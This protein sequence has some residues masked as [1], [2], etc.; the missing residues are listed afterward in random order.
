MKEGI[1]IK[2]ISKSQAILLREKGLDKYVLNGHGQYHKYYVCENQD[3]LKL[4]ENHKKSIVV[5]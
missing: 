4:L 2:T 3:V 5:G 1:I